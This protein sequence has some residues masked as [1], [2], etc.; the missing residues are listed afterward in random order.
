M[1]SHRRTLFS[2]IYY[3]TVYG[4]FLAATAVTI[5]RGER[6]ARTI[7]FGIFGVGF[8]LL[9]KYPETMVAA[10][11]TLP[12]L[13]AFSLGGTT[14]LI[15]LIA[16]MTLAFCLRAIRYF[17]LLFDWP[18]LVTFVFFFYMLINWYF[19]GQEDPTFGQARLRLYFIRGVI[20]AA[21]IL[22]LDRVRQRL[23]DF[24]TS[25][26]LLSSISA[27]M[28]LC[29]YFGIG[30]LTKTTWGNAQRVGL[31]GFDPISFSLP[32]GIGLLML[33]YLF[34][35]VKNIFHKLGIVVIAGIMLFSIFPTGTRQTILSL[36]AGVM[37]YALVAYR[38]MLAKVFGSLLFLILL[39][40]MLFLFVQRL[41]SNRFDFFSGR[42][43]R[44]ESFKGRLH[45]MG[46]GMETFKK[47]PYFG[48]GA[49]GHGDFIYTTNPTTGKRSKDKSH[50][51]NLFVE[52]L[53]EQGLIGFVLYLVP[54]VAV[55]W[56]LTWNFL[57]HAE[58]RQLR[59][60][61]A[62]LLSLFCFA[63]VQSNI[64]G[65]ISVSGS[66]ITTLVAWMSVYTRPT[67][68]RLMKHC[69][70]YGV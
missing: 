11:H 45:T 17:K 46:Q 21:L 48:V 34:F 66:F 28:I 59:A 63:F 2:N 54:I 20:P 62:L 42:L 12:F 39:S 57:K 70:T 24:C 56:R 44:S 23:H 69:Q 5:L 52:L 64:S 50:I 16:T 55:L 9:L 31:L 18:V 10:I 3:K 7:A 41:Q 68:K 30:N 37:A 13:G 35:S 14:L 25:T 61:T 67:A 51:H 58:D 49:G 22:T 36:F 29:V 65:G 1:T 43:V 60:Q 4:L 15:V 40:L 47:A 53:A 32:V 26:A 8:G 33:L 38:H 6:A 19:S 27:F